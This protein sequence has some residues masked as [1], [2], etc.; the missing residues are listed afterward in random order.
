MTHDEIVVDV[1]AELNR[2]DLNTLISKWINRVY[3]DVLSRHS[4]TWLYALATQ[5]T[6]VGRF[7]YVVPTDF[8]CLRQVILVDGTSSRDL[9][10]KDIET[11][12]KLHPYPASD[13]QQRSTEC[14]IFSGTD[15]ESVPYKE[16]WL[17]P[18]PNGVY[19]LNVY[20]AIDTPALSDTRSPVI[21]TRHHAVLVYGSL[22]WGF[23]RLREYEAAAFWN[24]EMEKVVATLIK[25]DKYAPGVSHQLGEFKPNV[26]IG[27]DDH[28]SPFI[29]RV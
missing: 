12:N 16:I 24:N 15:A 28:L 6:V 21:P 7:R 23:A 20:Y 11:F 26:V 3:R 4:F 1:A 9:V 29:R 25:E 5:S 2:S 18:P 13:A 10:E 22:K 19:P 17:W 27:S 14:A 8:G